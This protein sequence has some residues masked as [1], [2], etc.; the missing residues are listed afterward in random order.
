ML[1]MN[2]SE[3]SRVARNFGLKGGEYA[4]Q[5]FYRY[6]YKNHVSEEM[7][8]SEAIPLS[9]F[10]LRD[11]SK[12]KLRNLYA[13]FIEKEMPIPLGEEIFKFWLLS[14]AEDLVDNV[15]KEPKEEQVTPTGERIV[16]MVFDNFD[17]LKYPQIKELME[18]ID[19]QN[20]IQYINEGLHA[21]EVDVHVRIEKSLVL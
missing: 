11:V 15:A 8:L 9:K 16:S 10:M 5:E 18:H 1:E 14:L 21:Y 19:R 12:D 13:S 20:L 2:M 7:F 6:L 17:V 3:F 4:F